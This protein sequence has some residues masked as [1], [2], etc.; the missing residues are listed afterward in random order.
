MAFHFGRGT[1]T[2]QDGVREIAID[3]IDDAIDIA[4]KNRNTDETVHYVRR[5]CKKLRGLLRL[6]RPVFAGYRAENTAFR[7]AARELSVLRD[8]AILIGT[9]DRLLDACQD[10]VDRARFAPIRRRLTLRQKALTKRASVGAPLEQFAQTMQAA[11]KRARQWQLDA[12]G[13]GALRG[14]IAKSYKDAK[15]AMAETSRD[16]NAEA[17]HEWRKRMKDHW[18]HTRLL[19]PIC[20]TLMKAHRDVADD[21]GE[22]LGNH[23]DLDVFM[24]HLAN[25]KL[26]DAA[27]R[28]V[29][30]RLVRRRQ[31][32]LED[33]AFLLGARLFAEP[34]RDLTA[35]WESY[36]DTWRSDRPRDA[37]LA[38]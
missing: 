13:F 31:K 26:A 30:A 16:P 7:D 8:G 34:A 12:D 1:A 23:H 35:R 2:I 3:L 27:D 4:R 6:V 24:R 22:L 38:A 37:A 21:L 28:G 18:Y 29:L 10:R 11:R 5:N 14:G 20:P 33:E 17:I 36:W 25:D 19:T 32:A 9:Y 15:R